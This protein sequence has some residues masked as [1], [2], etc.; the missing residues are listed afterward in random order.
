MAEN[1]GLQKMRELAGAMAEITEGEFLLHKMIL[2]GWNSKGIKFVDLLHAAL[3]PDI[4]VAVDICKGYHK[5]LKQ[6][7]IKNAYPMS[8]KQIAAIDRAIEAIK[9]KG[10]RY[11][12]RWNAEYRDWESSRKEK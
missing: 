9:A 5:R 2:E 3:A 1:K 8:D 7:G 4:W 11:T 12:Y 6:Y 10:S